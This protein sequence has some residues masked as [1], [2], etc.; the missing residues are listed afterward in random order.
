MCKRGVHESAEALEEPQVTLDLPRVL[1]FDKEEEVNMWNSLDPK[2]FHYPFVCVCTLDLVLLEY[3]CEVKLRVE[4]MPYVKRLVLMMLV[5]F[6]LVHFLQR[7]QCVKAPVLLPRLVILEISAHQVFIE[8]SV[9]LALV[10][11]LLVEAV[12]PVRN[13]H[14]CHLALV[15]LTVKF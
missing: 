3:L 7:L 15:A 8:Y 2:V 12:Q 6:K 9:R 10:K 11:E 1:V 5:R 14:Y 13:A 4:A